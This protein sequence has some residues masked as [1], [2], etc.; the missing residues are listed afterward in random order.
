MTEE[1]NNPKSSE[2]FI[3]EN[4]VTEV[5][6]RIQTNRG[7]ILRGLDKLFS[8]SRRYVKIFIADANESYLST[9]ISTLNAIGSIEEDGFSDPGEYQLDEW[10]N[11]GVIEVSDYSLETINAVLAQFIEKHQGV[12]GTINH[13][14]IGTIDLTSPDINMLKIGEINIPDKEF[15]IAKIDKNSI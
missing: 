15:T 4:E 13:T 2:V 11:G 10:E 1:N 3:P 12:N 7:K 5:T 9:I 14:R 8:G 6:E